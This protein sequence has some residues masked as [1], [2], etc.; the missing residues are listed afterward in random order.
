[1]RILVVCLGN[2]CRSP[3]A[4]AALV[5]ALADAG[6]HHVEVDSAGTGSWHLGDP[7]DPRMAAAAAE[8]GLALRGTAR[9]VTRADFDRFDLILC[10][11]RQNLADVV[12]LAPD[13]ASRAKV[14][15]FRELDPDA[16]GD[17]VPD[18]YYGGADGFASV[19]EIVRSAARGVVRHVEDLEGRS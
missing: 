14:R 1:V 16:D 13:E 18:P 4:E 12:A 7:P 15:L 6:I 17:D 10:M 3:T 2:I 9:Q 5:E 19:V 11:D 8:E